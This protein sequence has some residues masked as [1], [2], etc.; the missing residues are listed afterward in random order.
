MEY[1][2]KFVARI[3]IAAT[4]AVVGGCVSPPDP[5][6]VV[7]P[8]PL[9]IPASE[10]KSLADA[11]RPQAV[12][13]EIIKASASTTPLDTSQNITPSITPNDAVVIALKNNPTLH[14]VRLQRGLAEGGVVIAKTYPYN[15][16]LETFGL[17]DFGPSSAGITNHFNFQATARLD[18]ELR[19]QM[20]HRLSAAD[21]VV[22]RTEWEIAAQEVLVCVATTRAFNSVLYRNRKLEVLDDTVKLSQLVV[23]IVKR[24]VDGGRLRPADMILARTELDSA[25]AL[26]GQG[27]VALTVARADLRHQLG[28][29][30]DSFQVK[31]ELDLPLPT[32]EMDAYIKTALEVRPDLRAR[33]VAV[34]EAQ[35]RLRLQVA[36]RYGNISFGPSYEIDNT[37]VNYIGFALFAPIPVLNTHRGEI[38]QAQATVARSVADV[39]QMEVQSELEI[40]AALNRFAEA[41]KWADSYANEVLPNL[42]KSTQDMEKLLAQNDPGVDVL[43][44]IDVQRNY[45]RSFDAYLDALFEISQARADLAAAVGDPALALGL[46]PPQLAAPKPLPAPPK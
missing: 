32:A 42:R 11:S 37:Q 3:G 1:L 35:A 21:A 14:S 16:V 27:K 19:G 29:L 9:S 26:V 8:K 44:V 41:R 46:Y 15:P 38:M 34:D 24:L 31:G 4:V 20:K 25:R 2:S 40:Q 45:L 17:P 22:S 33:K 12:T 6:G 23:D 18:L 7:P 30:D 43:K 28:S 36:D 5:Y 39:K 13:G 10:R